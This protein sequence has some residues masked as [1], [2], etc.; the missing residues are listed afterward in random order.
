MDYIDDCVIRF[1]Q[2]VLSA[3]EAIYRIKTMAKLVPILKD[4]A[5]LAIKD[6]K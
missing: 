4:H 1:Q 6:I 5:K 3:K 2:N